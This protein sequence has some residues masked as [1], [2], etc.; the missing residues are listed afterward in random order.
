ME[1]RYTI[2]WFTG[3]YLYSPDPDLPDPDLLHPDL[4]DPDWLNHDLSDPDLLDP[5]LSDHDL[6]DSD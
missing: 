5:Y 1:P 2:P 4:P 3:A 6:L